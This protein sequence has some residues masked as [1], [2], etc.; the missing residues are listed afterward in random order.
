[1]TNTTMQKLLSRA[2]TAEQLG[3][4]VRKVDY[5]R[6][7]GKLP[8]IKQGRRTL[9]H[10]QDIE[11]YIQKNRSTTQTPLYDNELIEEIGRSL[12]PVGIAAVASMLPRG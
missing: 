12:L 8:C 3:I 5:L 2:E 10:I 7:D 6:A 11:A 1:M 4:S 9:Y